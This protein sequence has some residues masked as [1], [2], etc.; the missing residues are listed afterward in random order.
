V[1]GGAAAL[2]AVGLVLPPVARSTHVLLSLGL[3]GAGLISLGFGL[4]ARRSGTLVLAIALLGSEQAVWFTTSSSLDPWTPF[5]AGG[6]LLVAELAWWSIEPRARA[7]IEHDATLS[8]AGSVIT[9][10]TGGTLLAGLVMFAAEAP[11]RGGAGLVLVGVVAA[12]AAL[13]LI[14]V[15]AFRGDVV[16]RTEELV[17]RD[18]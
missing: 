8:R 12:T 16:E 18:D 11:L 15:V 7:W 1:T 13:A 2:V 14:A 6:F 5:Y 3:G 10:C 9:T 4:V 17:G